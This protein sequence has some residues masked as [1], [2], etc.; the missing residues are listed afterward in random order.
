MFA[1]HRYSIL[2][3]FP[4]YINDKENIFG[5][6]CLNEFSLP[7][8]RTCA[9]IWCCFG[10]Y[11]CRNIDKLFFVYLNKRIDCSILLC[12][13]LC[14]LCKTVFCVNRIQNSRQEQKYK[15]FVLKMRWFWKRSKC[16]GSKTVIVVL[17]VTMASE[18]NQSTETQG[19]SHIDQRQV[20]HK[21]NTWTTISVFP[22]ICQYLLSVLEALLFPLCRWNPLDKLGQCQ[23]FTPSEIKYSSLD[24]LMISADV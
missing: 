14:F 2:N 16:R 4:E 21:S 20:K 10:S 23:T 12:G 5:L 1:T 9:K 8:F 3:H 11:L 18:M 19:T 6:I 7:T 15:I 22:W 13:V 17:E 24:T